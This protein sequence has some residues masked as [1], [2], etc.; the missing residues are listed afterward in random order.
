M[1]KMLLILALFCVPSE[2]NTAQPSQETDVGS[3]AVSARPEQCQHA[4][5]VELWQ[6]GNRAE[7]LSP[8]VKRSRGFWNSDPR[9]D[10]S[11]GLV[12]ELPPTKDCRWSF[13][14]LPAGTYVAALHS[15]QGSNGSRDFHI[16]AESSSVSITVPE[17]AARI[18]G[19]LLFSDRPIADAQ[20]EFVRVP[21]G[22]G[23]DA[24]TTTNTDGDGRYTATLN[25]PGH[26]AVVTTIGANPLQGP[27]PPIWDWTEVVTGSNSWDIVRSG[28]V[29]AIRL[30]GR[31]EQS[32]TTVIV[33]RG[34]TTKLAMV[35]PGD[36][37]ITYQLNIDYGQ[38]QVLA[39][40]PGRRV[41][42]G[43][44]TS[45]I[46]QANQVATID[47][48]LVDNHSTLSVLDEQSKRP[49]SVLVTGWSGQRTFANVRALSP[50]IYDLSPIPP[51]TEIVVQPRGEHLVP[52]C[53]VVGLNEQATV[54]LKLGRGVDAIFER[55][56]LAGPLG[57][58]SGVEGSNCPIPLS[59][60]Q[61]QRMA[62]P[63]GAPARGTFQNFPSSRQL[64]FNY[65]DLAQP[66]SMPDDS[67]VIFK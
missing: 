24:I 13:N 55:R 65:A 64:L 67:V 7:P 22:D 18:S 17:P 19:R 29:L 16:T 23:I 2:L 10:L 48:E 39:Y 61:Y 34:D 38:Y 6:V 4:D 30:H 27:N 15:P 21:A 25:R 57:L 20:I 63:V 45:A 9:V 14:S 66:V 3:V 26:Y 60:F 35:Q 5:R 53:R 42:A 62:T 56:G 8:R 31:D 40:Q 1:L 51:G 37:P 44:G 49:V 50:G 52:S 58:L 47:L 12:A 46:S 28:T 36:H 43:P 54:L 41:S 59:T 32:P 11:F 33:R